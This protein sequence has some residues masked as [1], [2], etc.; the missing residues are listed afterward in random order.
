M[1]TDISAGFFEHARQRFSEYSSIMSFAK[2]DIE[3]DPKSQGFEENAYD[4]IIAGNVLHATSDLCASLRNV[5]RLLKPGGK[6]IM[7]EICNPHSIREGLIFGLLS[8]WWLRTQRSETDP[9]SDCVVFP[10][11]GPL[12]TEGQWA[13][14]LSRC[15]FSGVDLNFRDHEAL[16]HHRLSTLVASA[17]DQ[18]APA[19]NETSAVATDI[20]I[21]L[22]NG[23]RTQNDL[24]GALQRK[25]AGL[26]HTLLTEDRIPEA[27]FRNATVVVLLELDSTMLHDISDVRMS[28]L[29]KMS[30]ESRRCL[31]VVSGGG[32]RAQR[33]E[34]EL[35]IG[36]SRTV[37]SERG[38][39]GFVVVSLNPDRLGDIEHRAGLVSS[40]LV[41]TADGGPTEARVESELFEVDGVLQI[42]RVAP[43]GR[44]NDAVDSRMVSR[45]RKLQEARLGSI[46]T[47]PKPVRLTIGSPGLLDTLQFKEMPEASQ[48]LENDEVEIRVMASSI[49]FKDVMI[50]L[51]Q[52]P[53]TN[54]GFGYDGAGVV[55]RTGP[56]CQRARMGDRV[57]FVAV[58]GAFAT[59]VRV[60]ELQT[61]II[62]ASMSMTVAASVP[63][64][65]SLSTF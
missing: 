29:K 49:N 18:G 42:P 56:T 39:Q 15:G 5:R 31:W 2:L 7:V 63:V 27:N 3:H 22:D 36:F 24:A 61:H 47:D 16:P 17:D 35:S 37:C 23:S 44:L 30:L 60:S 53:G 51:G 26:T 9:E 19:G 52:I 32:P 59:F 64:V 41:G 20:V 54:H 1:Y 38:D 13:D 10:D 48:A 14:V 11:Q 58:T 25:F 6:L 50:A 4:V 34:A 33:P 57:M 28:A 55:V 62:P 21:V 45:Q 40:V 12:L 46:E 65:S 8:G 43:S